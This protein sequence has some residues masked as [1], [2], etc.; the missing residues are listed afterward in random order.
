[1]AVPLNNTAGQSSFVL[2]AG[3]GQAF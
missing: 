1:V 2:Y 3:I